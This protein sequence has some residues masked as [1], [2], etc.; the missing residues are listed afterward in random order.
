[1]LKRERDKMLELLSEERASSARRIN[2]LKAELDAARRQLELER[3]RSE[4]VG[5]DTL[6]T[7]PQSLR[8]A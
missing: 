6:T 1:M 8:T 4:K 3:K 7:I 5:A 2:T